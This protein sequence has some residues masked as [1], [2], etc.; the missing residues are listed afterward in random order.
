MFAAAFKSDSELL[1][2]FEAMDELP[3]YE[4]A[5]IRKK[6]RIKNLPEAKK[7]LRKLVLKAMN[8]YHEELNISQQLRRAMNDV[9][10]LLH[11]NLF[12][13][14]RKEIHKAWKL[15]E[16]NTNHCYSSEIL[17]FLA[18]VT[19]YTL[20][21]DKLA[22]DFE[23]F[24]RLLDETLLR[25]QDF[26]RAQMF[27]SQISWFM[28]SANYES[29]AAFKAYLENIIAQLQ[30]QLLS[31]KTFSA[32][33]MLL[34]SLTACYQTIGHT[35]GALATYQQMRKDYQQSPSL[36]DVNSY[37]Y[38]NYLSNFGLLAAINK[39]YK[40]LSEQLLKE[41]EECFTRLTEFFK[42]NPAK[43]TSFQGTLICNKL[44][45]SKT[46]RNWDRLNQLEKEVSAYIKET[47]NR[48]P[49]MA[50][51]QVA[52]L[53]SCFYYQGNYSRAL[54]WV[55]IYYTLDDAKKVKVMMVCV[56]LLEVFIHHSNGQLDISDNKAVNLYKTFL[57]QEF[58]DPYYKHLGTLL[59]RLNR[60]NN[61]DKNDRKEME[62]LITTF[63]ELKSAENRQYNILMIHFEPGDIL[64]KLLE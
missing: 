47:E 11:K 19:S 14:A 49:G 30:V 50:A 18:Y 12:E 55:N 4:E 15:A 64:Q 8:N 27:G 17:H 21:A 22:P 13:E 31:V 9:S 57:E 53:I 43:A 48:E 41:G 62:N 42:K 24:H 45:Y 51:A 52:M 35:D 60:W 16:N 10:F 46:Q 58:K 59:R 28:R 38:L 32:R 1:K 61:D 63:D 37:I 6:T 29:E 2:L 36:I 23:T 26:R 5:P 34:N 54:E 56:R 33:G 40:E 25:E 20:T 7:N 44:S 3:D 39:E